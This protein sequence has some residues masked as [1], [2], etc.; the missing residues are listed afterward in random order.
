MNFDNGK[1]GRSQ[2][3]SISLPGLSGIARFE[4][5][6]GSRKPA[7]SP[8][9]EE[10]RAALD[11]LKRAGLIVDEGSN[12]RDGLIFFL[13]MADTH[14]SVQK[15]NPTG[16]P[17]EPHEIEPHEENVIPPIEN[18]GIENRNPIRNPTEQEA[19][20][21]TRQETGK[22]KKKKEENARARISLSDRFTWDGITDEDMGLWMLAYPAIDIRTE[23]ARA[24][25]WLKNNPK[26][27]KSDFP[28]FLNGW[29]QRAQDRAPRVENKKPQSVGKQTG[30][31]MSAAEIAY[32]QIFGSSLQERDIT[33]EA[34]RV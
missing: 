7:W 20:N 31:G 13:P 6:W 9:K 1:V 4:P 22:K 24:A 32:Q 19:R 23:L 5:D 11:E 27:M 33:D 18:S 28:R 17:Q 10:I 14:Q 12:L 15:R 34:S 3:C 8:T 29:M 21:P 16:T 30:A 25:V 26:N 2:G